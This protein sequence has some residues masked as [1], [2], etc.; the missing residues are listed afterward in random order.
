MIEVTKYVATRKDRAWCPYMRG[1]LKE[2]D[3]HSIRRFDGGDALDL[4]TFVMSECVFILAFIVTLHI[5][6]KIVMN[7]RQ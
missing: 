2:V 1:I 4:Y 5:R 7:R 6:Q 3:A